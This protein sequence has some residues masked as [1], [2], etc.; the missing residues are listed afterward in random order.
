MLDVTSAMS[1]PC[2]CLDPPKDNAG[3]RHWRELSIHDKAQDTTCP[4]WNR[5]VHLVEEVADDGREEFAPA[6]DLGPADW[7][8]I[9]TL[10][11]TIAKLKSVKHLLLYGSNLVRIPPEIGEMAN[12]EKFTPYTS[13]RLHWFPYEITRCMRLRESTVSTRALYGNYKYRLPFPR[14]PQVSGELTPKYCSV[15]NDPL[16]NDSLRQVWITLR[17]ATDVLPLL[18]HACTD[19]C[20]ARLPKPPDDYFP[21]PH[22]GGIDL[23][24][25]TGTY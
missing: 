16:L 7:A 13:Y 4:A 6:R 24:Q 5:L 22:Q 11:P 18:V 20:I 17:V 1:T 8:R 10:P 21:R 25:P 12:L 19:E 14:L 23:I 2:N 3:T 9:T 15:C